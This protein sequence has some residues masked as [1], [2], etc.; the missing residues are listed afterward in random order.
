MY[1]AETM[2]AALKEK[3]A[4]KKFHL[5]LGALGTKVGVTSKVVKSDLKEMGYDK[6]SFEQLKTNIKNGKV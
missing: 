2:Q 1:N 5:F 3:D 6:G 4:A